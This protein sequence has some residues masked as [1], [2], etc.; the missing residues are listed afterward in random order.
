MSACETVAWLENYFIGNYE[1]WEVIYTSANTTIYSWLIDDGIEVVWTTL[2]DG[3]GTFVTVDFYDNATSGT[4]YR[5]GN[6]H[7]NCF[8]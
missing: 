7:L 3:K 2:P 6:A 1:D 4:P 8:C 5:T